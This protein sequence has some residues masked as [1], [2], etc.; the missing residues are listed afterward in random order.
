MK[1]VITVILIIVIVAGAATGAA[2][3]FL[4]N[5]PAS[6]KAEV[7]ISAKFA[8][9]TDGYSLFEYLDKNPERYETALVE[10]Y[11]MDEATRE[12]LLNEPEEWLALFL[13]IDIENPNDEEILVESLDIPDNGK[14]GVYIQ[15]A[16][17]GTYVLEPNNTTQIC[18]N[19]FVDTNEPSYDEVFAMIKEMKL[20]IKYAPV[21]ADIADLTEEDYYKVRIAE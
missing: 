11:G 5:K 18:A 2:V 19:V 7:S 13:F 4:K 16:L 20:Y 14:N 6:D 21:P 10:H 3:Y 9:V 1:K 17:D 12:R 15:T 8:E